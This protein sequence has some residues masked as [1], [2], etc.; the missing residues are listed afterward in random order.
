MRKQSEWVHAYLTAV[1]A[2]GWSVVEVQSG[3]APHDCPRTADGLVAAFCEGEDL[4]VGVQNGGKRSF[5]WFVWQGPDAT[6]PDGDEVLADYGV[7]LDTVV[8]SVVR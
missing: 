8:E 4:W 7:T 1:L 3:D 6:Y 5:L 2:A